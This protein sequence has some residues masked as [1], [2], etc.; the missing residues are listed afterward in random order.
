VKID[1]KLSINFEMFLLKEKETKMN[2]LS[3]FV[4]SQNFEPSPI[5]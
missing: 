4:S 1:K 3:V 5:L 2:S